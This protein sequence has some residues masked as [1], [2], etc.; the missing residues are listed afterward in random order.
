MTPLQIA[1]VAHEINRAYCAAIG[2]NSQPAWEDAPDWQQRSAANGVQLHLDNP[3]TTPEQSHEAWL[4]QKVAE[5]WKFGPVKNPEAKE[6]P[7]MVP[8]EQLPVEQR[9]KDHL[10][11]AVVRS[12]APQE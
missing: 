11:A 6:H 5:G 3:D 2:D 12:L 9:V 8:Y 10:F 4:E 1:R 7:C